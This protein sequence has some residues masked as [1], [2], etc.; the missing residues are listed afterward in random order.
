MGS[1]HLQHYHF[2][3]HQG[4]CASNYFPENVNILGRHQ[5][6]AAYIP[7]ITTEWADLFTTRS[8]QVVVE[9]MA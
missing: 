9:Y 1:V 3:T 2:H 5:Y 6:A 4:D 8:I 7:A